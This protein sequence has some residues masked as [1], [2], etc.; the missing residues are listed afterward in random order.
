MGADDDY[1]STSRNFAGS[2]LED[3]RDYQ[4][5]QADLKITKF[6]ACR[7]GTTNES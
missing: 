1:L 2:A 5:Y 7:M 4:W 6:L 3:F